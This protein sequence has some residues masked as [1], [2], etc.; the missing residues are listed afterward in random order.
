MP[1]VILHLDGD[2]SVQLHRLA[3][4]RGV[5]PSRVVAQLLRAEAPP[6]W[7]P[8]FLS[9]LGS[10]PDFSLARE[11]RQADVPDLPRSRL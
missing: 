6:D 5:S 4:Q 2:T 11:L 7:P 1:K 8:D 10:C 3:K 9:A